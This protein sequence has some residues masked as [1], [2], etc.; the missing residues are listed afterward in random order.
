MNFTGLSLDQAPPISVPLR[1][2]LVAP[3]FAI[4]AALVLFNNGIENLER[5]SPSTI[6][7]THFITIGFFGFVMLGALT[8][9]LPVIA[10]ATIKKVDILATFVHIFIILGVLSMVYG[11]LY[12]LNTILVGAYILLGLGFVLMLVSIMN[13]MM[14]VT[15]FTPTIK[16]MFL[17]LTFAFIIV[18]I[19]IF[20]LYEYANGDLSSVHINLANIHATL[21]IF[22]FAILLIVGVVFQVLPMFYVA[23]DFGSFFEERF[24]YIVGLGLIAW[25][26]CSLFY[27]EYLFIIKIFLMFCFSYFSYALW[28]KFTTRKR[29][30]NDITVLYFKLATVFLVVGL[31]VWNLGEIIVVP[32][33]ISGVFIGGFIMASMQGMLYK[34]IPFLIWFHLN[35]KGYMNIKTMNEMINKKLAFAQFGMFVVSVALFIVSNFVPVL[36]EISLIVFILSMLILEYNIFVPY[37]IY[38]KTLKKKPDFDM[39]AFGD[40]SGGVS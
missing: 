23:P 8:Q 29:K 28:N 39:A 34:I 12:S 22:G 27:E 32:E 36:F 7:A 37:T 26:V 20:L 40:M 38:T 16:A 17:S 2:F 25:S 6:A 30:I 4:L 35:A 13:S 1:F 19:G 24:V 31:F 33:I 18:M 21:A 11:L 5:F 15:H 10:N 9:M 14:S 3:F